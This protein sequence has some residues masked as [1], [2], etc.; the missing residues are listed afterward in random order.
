MKKTLTLFALS[1]TIFA[2][3]ANCTISIPGGIFNPTE[4]AGLYANMNLCLPYHMDWTIILN[5]GR[6]MVVPRVYGKNEDE[7]RKELMKYIK[8]N[9]R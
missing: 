8:Q 1:A 5:D 3:Q 7:S 9:C 6:R 4:V 2:A